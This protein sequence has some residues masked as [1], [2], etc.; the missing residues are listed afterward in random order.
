MLLLQY[1]IFARSERKSQFIG[2][3]RHHRQIESTHSSRCNIAN[4]HQISL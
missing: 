4:S 1:G 3:K 2:Q